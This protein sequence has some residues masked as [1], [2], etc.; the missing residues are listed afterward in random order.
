ML[1]AVCPVGES[2]ELTGWWATCINWAAARLMC[3]TTPLT[4]QEF[5]VGKPD[6]NWKATFHRAEIKLPR[7]R[8][9][10]CRRL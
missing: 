1:K 8:G 9:A 4:G 2:I 6:A 5:R 10:K 3:Y 7:L